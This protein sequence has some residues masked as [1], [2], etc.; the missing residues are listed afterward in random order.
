[1]N[2]KAWI[3]KGLS[4]CLIAAT[5]ST[6]SMVALAS[7]RVLGELTVSGDS[8]KVNGEIAQSGKTIFSTNTITTNE[9]SGATVSFGKL[10]SI[11]IA[12]NTAMKVT[13]D[14]SSINGD[15]ATGNV[16]VFGNSEKAVSITTPSG[17]VV[18]DKAEDKAFTVSVEQN[19][20]KVSNEIGVVTFNENNKITSV[21]AGETATT[22]KGAAK[23]DNDDYK[24]ANGKCIDKN[25][26]GVLECDKGAAAWWIWT[27]V[28]GGAVA[29][30]LI[31]A[32]SNNNRV[33][34]GGGTTVVSPTR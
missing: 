33:S 1:M 8:V 24:D 30:V 12:P 6:Y 3:N 32:T 26:N 20:A 11:E 34:L 5:F 4:A 14:D 10:G 31:A 27:A 21:K 18:S 9:T 16:K 19:V 15:L 22:G 17:N 29:G 28:F 2:S 13:F 23:S 25:N 7:N